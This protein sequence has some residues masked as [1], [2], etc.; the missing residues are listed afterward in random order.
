MRF[1]K[2][3]LSQDDENVYLDAYIADPT[4]SYTRK[5]ILVIPGG[6]YKHV[7]AD[8]EGEP[9]A[10]AFLPYGYNAFVLHYTVN[11]EKTFPIQLI[12]VAK[13]IKH[14]KDHAE[15]YG[16]DPN[17][18]FTVGFSAGGHLSASA[19][20]LWKLDAIQKAVEMPFG[21]NKPKGCMLIYPVIST[22]CHHQGSFQNLWATKEPTEEQL[23]AVSIEKHVDGDSAPAFILHTANDQIVDVNNSLAIAAAYSKAEVPFELH[24]YPDAP[25]GVALGN[26][27]TAG[28]TEQWNRPA[29]AEWVR[30]AAYWAAHL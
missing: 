10:L 24:I 17:E 1:E 18:L 13:A 26:K 22:D 27:I 8:R 2:I 30:M 12:E 16:I 23:A 5:A 4:K 6:G 20:V 29:I 3:L 11:S 25:H 14:I 9:I 19:G 15:D 21:Y 28:E 7:C